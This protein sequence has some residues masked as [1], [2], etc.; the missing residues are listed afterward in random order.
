MPS[1]KLKLDVITQEKALLSLNVDKISAPAILGEVTILPGHIP[2]F[3]RLED[4]IL[5][6]WSDNK[7]DELAVIGGFMDVAPGNQVTI[8][9]D[10]AII[11]SSVS[12]AAAEAAKE[13]AQKAMQEKT[14]EFEYKQAEI[15]L[16]RALM[17]L[18]VARRHNK[19]Q[20]LSSSS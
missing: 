3:T 12:I 15:S 13:K 2:L 6:Y 18:K 11:A 10:S 17:E 4:G 7:Y 8:M 16:R 5:K 14:S 9:A 19:P 1:Q 20:S